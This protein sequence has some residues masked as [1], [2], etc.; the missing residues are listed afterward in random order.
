MKPKKNAKADLNKRT[1]LFLQLGLIL[2]LLLAYFAINWKNY[3]PREAKSDT[4]EFTALEEET[5]PITEFKT[6]PPSQPPKEP[7]IIEVIED[8]KPVEEDII[9]PTEIDPDEI[10]DVEDIV[11]AEE[12]EPVETVS[13][14][15]IESVPVFPG[16]EMLS[17]NSARKACM[18]QKITKFVNDNFD[19]GLGEEL[20]L[21]GINRVIVVFK[22]DTEGNV[23]DIK[24][25]APHP[26]LEQEA[27][28]VMEA[29]PSMEPGKQRG[30]PV[31]VSYS[32]PIIF[33]VQD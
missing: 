29:L 8:D 3:D 12:E 21:S 6:P 14:E 32:L 9:E 15:V 24:S 11:E 33:K 20:G 28:R 27:V 25:R 26:G 10:A 1:A 17:D 7:T 5:I 19:T 16:C 22:I 4:L 13:F 31:N 23:I 18:S 2:V 30:K